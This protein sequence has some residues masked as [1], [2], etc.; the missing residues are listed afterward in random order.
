MTNSILV[1]VDISDPK[2]NIDLLK[3]A[4]EMAA[5]QKAQLDVVTVLPDFGMS[6]V[7][8]YFSKDHSKQMK[9]D[10]K[11]ALHDLVTDV[12]GK[13][14][15][16]NVRHII[17]SGTAYEEVLKAAKAAESSLIVVGA[18]K[19]DLKDFLLGPN[20]ARIV[21]HSNCSVYVVR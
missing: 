14:K 16:E 1:A 13:E 21:R 8:G 18:H 11:L 6:Q 2:A 7:G 17:A 3:K 15:N 4:D 19:P 20:A 5:M 12:L 10:A 9:E